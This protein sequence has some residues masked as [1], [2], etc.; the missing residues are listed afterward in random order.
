[1]MLPASKIL[2][3]LLLRIPK[4]LCHRA[5]VEL[6]EKNWSAFNIAKQKSAVKL[7]AI[8]LPD[9]RAMVLYYV[10]SRAKLSFLQPFPI[11]TKIFHN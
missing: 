8:N 9:C 5:K 3:F 10:Y 11:I 2:S 6:Q 7:A 4:S 1:M